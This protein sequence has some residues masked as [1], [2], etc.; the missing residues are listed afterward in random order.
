MPICCMCHEDK[1]PEA[2]AFRSIATGELQSH[3][4]E[5]QAAYR[6]K[7]YLD[8]KPVYIAREVARI[9]RFRDENRVLL[10]QYLVAHPCVDCGERD[11]LVLEFDHR[12]PRSK[13][14]DVGYL[15]V[16]K[17]WKFVL[18]EI[19]KCDVRCANC[20]RKRTAAQFNWAKVDSVNWTAVAVLAT[21]KVTPLL[22]DSADTKRCTRCGTDRPI[23][24]FVI[25]NKRT[26]QRGS[27]CRACRSAYGKQHYRNNASA[28]R[29]RA[30]RNRKAF[31]GRNRSRMLAYLVGKSCVDCGVAD[32]VLLEFDH[33]DGLQKEAEVARLIVTRQWASVDLEIAKCDI[34]CANCHRRRTAMQ[35]AWTK[36]TLQLEASE[37]AV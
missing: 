30:K 29:A 13:T 5:C 19:A 11:V 27:W 23:S 6:R 8:N 20:H 28:Y 35:F 33:R 37:Q 36:V 22:A 15:A 17:P 3:C 24:E 25:K 14:H 32:P 1:P 12:D 26:G 21:S 2:F 34:R 4:R 16:R 10:F 18:A 9:K 7:H 31:R